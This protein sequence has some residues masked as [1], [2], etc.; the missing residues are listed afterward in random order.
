MVGNY[1]S[2]HSVP[3][4]NAGRQ[5]P[6]LNYSNSRSRSNPPTGASEK[7][8]EDLFTETSSQQPRATLHS[9]LPMRVEFDGAATASDIRTIASS[10]NALGLSEL[11][12]EYLK[13]A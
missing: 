3:L 8:G 5:Y 10:D 11:P 7:N 4:S 6:T 2:W 9:D 1:V 12:S 13:A